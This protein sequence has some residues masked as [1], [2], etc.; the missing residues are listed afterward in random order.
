VDRWELVTAVAAE[1]GGV[2]QA[3]QALAA[4]FNRDEI[5]S[6]YRSGRWRRLARGHYLVGATDAAGE[7]DRRSRIR[8][9]ISAAGTEACAVLDTA[10]E[11]LGIAGLPRRVPIHVNVPGSRPRHQRVDHTVLLH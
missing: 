10:A 4:G 3:E 9:A 2:V 6:L 5:R 7:D 1:Q 11:L 8:A